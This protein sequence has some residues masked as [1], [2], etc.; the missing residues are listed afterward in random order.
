MRIY[1]SQ[2]SFTYFFI[3]TANFLRYVQITNVQIRTKCCII[4]KLLYNEN[5]SNSFEVT[6]SFTLFFGY[7]YYFVLG[8][9][10]IPGK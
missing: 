10:C 3:N 9:D 8:A 4:L 6:V 1:V 5:V 7:N 2:Y